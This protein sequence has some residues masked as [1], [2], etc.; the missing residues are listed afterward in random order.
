ML[1]GCFYRIEANLNKV[2][3]AESVRA[4]AT[5]VDVA[6]GYGAAATGTA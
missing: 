1:A 4:A 3:V 5:S 2:S 6:A